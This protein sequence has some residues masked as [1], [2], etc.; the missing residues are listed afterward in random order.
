QAMSTVIKGRGGFID[1]GVVIMKTDGKAKVKD[2]LR[3][4]NKRFLAAQFGIGR[5]K[6]GVEPVIAFLTPA[7]PDSHHAFN[8]LLFHLLQDLHDILEGLVVIHPWRRDI[9]LLVRALL[10][11][12]V[13]WKLGVCALEQMNQ[14][15]S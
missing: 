12:H 6:I 14:L 7:P 5:Q 4:F 11:L 15:R 10:V 8:A 1:V 9:S 3:M 2:L 13:Y